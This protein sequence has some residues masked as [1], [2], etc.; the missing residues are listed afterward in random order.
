MARLH[1]RRLL[2][3]LRHRVMNRP[4]TDPT[5]GARKFDQSKPRVELLPARVLEDVAMV[6]SFGAEKYDDHNWRKGFVWSRMY[7]AALRH[8]F[9]WADSE[10]LDPESG[11][12][13]LAHALC[14]IMFLQEYSHTNAGQDDRWE[15]EQLT[16]DDEMRKNGFDAEETF[17]SECDHCTKLAGTYDGIEGGRPACTCTTSCGNDI[18]RVKKASTIPTAIVNPIVQE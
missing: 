13:H 12:P 5:T 6:L 18:C 9:A 14:C 2:P 15:N 3:D 8:L 1:D 10:D 7:G 16:F 17:G 4:V 11:L